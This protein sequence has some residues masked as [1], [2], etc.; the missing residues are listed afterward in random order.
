MSQLVGQPLWCYFADVTGKHKVFLCTSLALG[1]SVIFTMLYFESF[2]HLALVLGA[3]GL[4]SSG[5]NPMIDSATMACIEHH[6]ISPNRYGHLR[7]FGEIQTHTHYLL[8][9][10]TFTVCIVSHTCSKKDGK[11]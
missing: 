2:L 1:S 5:V 3:G 9:R 8:T 10:F 7:V 4:L 6:H 11:H